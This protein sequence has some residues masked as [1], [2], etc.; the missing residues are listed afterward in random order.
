MSAVA[1][2]RRTL[3]A[4]DHDGSRRRGGVAG[5]MQQPEATAAEAR[6][7]GLDHGERGTDG[8]RGVEGVAAR[9]QEID[10]RGRRGGMCARHS[11]RGRA[12]GHGFRARGTRRV[13]CE[14]SISEHRGQAR[15]ADQA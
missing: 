12:I 3:A 11:R 8:D 10:S 7:V 5:E 2:E 13:P 9:A 15:G 1:A 6:S 14:H 4:V